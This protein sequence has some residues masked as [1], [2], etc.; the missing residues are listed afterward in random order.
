MFEAASATL[1][2][3]GYEHYEVPPAVGAPARACLPP[4]RPLARTS[5]P[6]SPPP[7]AP[8]PAAQISNYARPGHR[9]RHNSVYW[10]CAPYYAF[11]LGAASYARGRRFTRP[12][13]LP[14]YADWVAAFVAADEGCPAAALP[15]E[16]EVGARGARGTGAAAAG[17]RQRR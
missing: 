9:S 1:T 17:S 3:A 4:R 13:R 15:P 7:R 10:D 12:R 8:L 11:G 5:P 2:A 14:E 16:S 6:R